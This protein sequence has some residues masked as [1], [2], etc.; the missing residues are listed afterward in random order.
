MKPT[1]TSKQ[2]KTCISLL[3]AVFVGLVSLNTQAQTA[4]V[5]SFNRT[6]NNNDT[7]LGYDGNPT[8]VEGN[9]RSGATNGPAGS[10]VTGSPFYAPTTN[11]T[12]STSAWGVSNATE[13]VL[14]RGRQTAAASTG[15]YIQFRVAAWGLTDNE[16]MDENDQVDVF[17]SVDNGLSYYNILR[18]AGKSSGG[19]EGGGGNN[20]FWDY[21]AAIP[22]SVPFSTTAETTVVGPDNRTGQGQG[23]RNQNGFGFDNLKITLPDGAQYVRF[24]IIAKCDA[25]ELWTIDEVTLGSTS[26]T[27]LPVALKS[28]SAA[29]SAKGTQLHWATASEKN[30]AAFEVQRGSTAE[31]FQTIG[32]V[33]GQGTTSQGHTYSW[34]D[35]QPLPGLSYYRLRQLDYD[36]TESFSP[37]VVVQQS[38]ELAASFFPNPSSGLVT[39]APV[40][41]EVQ[42]RVINTLGQTVLTGRSSGGS[43]VDVQSLR[44]GSYFLELQSANGR[45]VERFSRE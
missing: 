23:R 13:G 26:A 25:D 42:Y 5:Q 44:A 16:G 40:L 14:F 36:G 3:S 4:V 34:I 35:K 20:N 28:F 32:R 31:Q 24:Y 17:V 30:N 22:K 1:F 38:T 21:R 33:S 12:T 2:A 18:I 7:E 45:T 11:G 6:N 37:V 29:A 41:G 27:P 19:G 10:M 9:A 8:I 43:T 15:N 39:L